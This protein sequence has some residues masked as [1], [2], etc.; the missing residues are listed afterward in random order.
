MTLMVGRDV[1]FGGSEETRSTMGWGAEVDK[2]DT[3]TVRGVQ[4][5]E[6]PSAAA[7]RA[8]GG[9]RGSSGVHR[10]AYAD[11]DACRTGFSKA[12]GIGA[13]AGAV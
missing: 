11:F 13:R 1:A 4:S 2:V 7:G 10:P 5:D 8:I 6:V 9:Q 12:G 3:I